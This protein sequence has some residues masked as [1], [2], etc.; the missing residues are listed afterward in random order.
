[1]TNTIKSPR[2]ETPSVDQSALTVRKG[3]GAKTAV[4]CNGYLLRDGGC[5]HVR[6]KA[7]H[8][9]VFTA[10]SMALRKDLM[11]RC[12]LSHLKNISTCQRQTSGLARPC[13]WSKRP[14]S[15]PTRDP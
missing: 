9:C 12:G 6:T 15:R 10:F 4:P 3:A 2:L 13:C 11:R 14:A 7:H 5:A 1:M 8:S